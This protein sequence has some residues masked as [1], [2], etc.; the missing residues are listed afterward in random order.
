M[1]QINLVI[2]D[3]FRVTVE[4]HP[5][6]ELDLGHKYT[7]RNIQGDMT[8]VIQ[9]KFVLD[10]FAETNILCYKVGRMGGLSF[11]T[12]FALPPEQVWVYGEESKVELPYQPLML[13]ASVEKY[14]ATL[15]MALEEE[16]NDDQE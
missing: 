15:V 3:D 6:W 1:S 13:Q 11:Y 5:K 9:D 16:E 8:V 10:F 12:S 2:S 4:R 7:N 14:I